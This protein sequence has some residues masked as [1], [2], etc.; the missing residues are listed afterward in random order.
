[1]KTHKKDDDDEA[2][3]PKAAGDTVDFEDRKKRGFVGALEKALY[4]FD[5]LHKIRIVYNER[6]DKG[7]KRKRMYDTKAAYMKE[8]RKKIKNE[9]VTGDTPPILRKTIKKV[10][11][12]VWR[13]ALA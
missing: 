7:Q 2:Y 9:G 6:K 4:K 3:N 8:Y 1:M 11:F 10:L 5:T 13:D 12:T